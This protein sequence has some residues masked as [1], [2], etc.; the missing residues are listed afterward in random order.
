[1]LESGGARLEGRHWNRRKSA[2]GTQ[3]HR[4]C[5]RLDDNAA[6]WG[7]TKRSLHSWRWRYHKNVVGDSYGVAKVYAAR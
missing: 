7:Y 3:K 5:H 6:R 4:R 2:T 1:M